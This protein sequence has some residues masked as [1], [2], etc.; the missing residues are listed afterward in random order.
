MSNKRMNASGLV[1]VRGV[2]S[3]E[4]HQWAKLVSIHVGKPLHQIVGEALEKFVDEVY[5]KFIAGEYQKLLAEGYEKEVQVSFK[6]RGANARNGE[7]LE[8][9]NPKDWRLSYTCREPSSGGA[10][11]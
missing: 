5:P 8:Y 10:P 2:L 1:M 9:R 4:K 7:R 11:R 3:R 6:P